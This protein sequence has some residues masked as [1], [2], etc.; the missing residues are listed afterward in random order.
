MRINSVLA[1]AVRT[2]ILGNTFGL[3]AGLLAATPVMAQAPAADEPVVLEEVTVT[4]RK[5]EETVLEVPIAIAA[6]STAKLEEAGI[7][8]VSDLGAFAPG[9]NFTQQVGNGPGG[10]AQGAIQFRGMSSQQGTNRE[11]SGSIFVDGIFVS[12]GVASVDT[13]DVQRVEILRGPQNAYFGRNTFGGAI[14]FVTRN[15]G[16]EFQGEV[17]AGAASH[18]GY[19]FRAKAEGPLI[20]GKLAGR[21]SAVKY[22][23]GAQYTANDGGDLGEQNTESLSGTLYATPT[24]NWTMRLRGHVQRDDDGA[25]DNAFVR[26]T[27][28]GS[29]CPG[30]TFTAANASGAPVSFALGRPYFCSESQIPS[31]DVLVSQNTSMFPRVLSTL[32]LPN[33]WYDIVANNSLNNP[34]LGRTPR[35]FDFGMKRNVAR[36][37]FQTDYTFANDITLA[38]SY[39]FDE[40]SQTTVYDP[41]RTDAENTWAVL[42]AISHAWQAEVRLQSGQEQPLRWL[43]GYSMFQGEWETQ[44]LAYQI[45]TA[46]GGAIPRVGVSNTRVDDRAET[47]AWFGSIEYDLLDNLTIGGEVRRQTD[48]QSS[49]NSDLV[50]RTS[51]EL[52]NTMPRYYVRYEPIPNLNLYA[53]YGKG[54]TP[55]QLNGNWN[56]YTPS[57]QAEVCAQFPSSC[58]GSIAKEPTVENYEIGI[59]QRLLGGRL[60][61]SLAAYQMDWNDVNTTVTVIVST[62]P[63]AI[64]FI[65]RNNAELKGLEFEGTFL[66]TDAWSVDLS[67]TWQKNEYTQF[68]NPAISTLTSGATYFTG[69]EVP[70]QPD[71]TAVLSST[72]RGRLNDSWRWFIRGDAMYTGKMWDS[73]ANIFELGGY[74]KI[75]AR[76]GFDRENLSVELYGR[77]IFD[78]DSW[79][80]AARNTSLAE[81]GALLSV[82]S[83]PGWFGYNPAL[84][85]AVTTV[86]GLMLNAPDK[87]EYGLRVTYRF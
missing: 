78:E 37:S 10:R 84:P 61:Y 2:A 50:T 68:Y 74:T 38:A 41:D 69:N 73:E 80:Y 36:V 64:P 34:I 63:F 49:L 8:S 17:T 57:Q 58:G 29:L 28:Y 19:D 79:A 66:I 85:N 72:Y 47:P 1:K 11:Q 67:A 39:G 70:K 15:P 24:D 21:L 52:K 83:Q 59:K 81:P 26:G 31:P 42:P 6:L 87:P 4:A 86:Q 71:K 60:Q 9:L 5:R 12:G 30:Q 7:K 32:G 22:R 46:V 20:E 55:G 82:R 53:T 56:S 77:N 45:N 16:D 65:V 62:T 14:N 27:Q 18:G 3:A 13:T 51:Y 40:S 48:K 25:M 23:K 33:L 35:M 44:Q 76:I 75:N 54:V 43:L